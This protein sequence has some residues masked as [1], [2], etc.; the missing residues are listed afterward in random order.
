MILQS[1]K[2][3]YRGRESL[4]LGGIRQ[5]KLCIVVFEVAS[6]VGNPVHS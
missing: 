1:Q 6:F 3:F 2:E 5:Y 4:I